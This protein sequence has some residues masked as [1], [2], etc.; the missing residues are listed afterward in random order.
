MSVLVSCVGENGKINGNATPDS[1][2]FL[3]SSGVGVKKS[4]GKK[5]PKV[6]V[7]S[8]DL[9]LKEYEDEIEVELKDPLID[10]IAAE[11]LNYSEATDRLIKSIRDRVF[12]T[13]YK[14][15]NISLDWNTT[16]Y[17]DMKPLAFF[18]MIGRAVGGIPICYIWY[19]KDMKTKYMDF[20]FW[21]GSVVFTTQ[22]KV[23]EGE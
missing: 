8:E 3:T 17:V 12:C 18:K 23:K 13:V 9:K 10:R 5:Y 22:I 11:A 16:S 15:S 21:Y 7:I 2:G 19:D 1:G 14:A 4:E 6:Y 20:Y